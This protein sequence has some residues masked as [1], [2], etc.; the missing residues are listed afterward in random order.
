MALEMQ[1]TKYLRRLPPGTLLVSGF[2][3][4]SQPVWHY[5]ESIGWKDIMRRVVMGTWNDDV[6]GRAAELAYFWM[7]SIFP[8]L[9]ILTVLLGYFAEGPEMRQDLAAYFE[10]VLPGSAFLLVRSTLTQISS[11]AG[12]GKLSFGIV[13]TLWAASSGMS[14]MMDGLNKAYEIP[15]T[16]PW[17]KA[18]LLAIVLTLGLAVLMIAALAILLYGSQLGGLMSNALGLGAVFR[19]FWSVIQWPLV[20]VFALLGFLFIYR[21]APNLQSQKF[22]WMLPGAGAGFILWFAL[23]MGLRVY[24]HYFP[25]Y[26]TVYGTLGALLLLLLWLY[27][28]SAALLIGG[29]LNSAIENAAARQGAPQAKQAGEVAPGE[30]AMPDAAEG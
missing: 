16:R 24:I 23:S 18:R 30:R 27:L 9:L 22:W 19:E 15:E 13:I 14:S 17:W 21:F 11:H 28:S 29:E 1:L 26:G 10:R 5:Y 2:S 6:F 4:L 7:F 3:S 12:T 20:V 25:S 8:L